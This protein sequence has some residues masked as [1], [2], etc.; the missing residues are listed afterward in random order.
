M[1]THAHTRARTHGRSSENLNDNP[2]RSGPHA[3]VLPDTPPNPPT[4]FTGKAASK[5]NAN[6][7]SWPAS[8]YDE[9]MWFKLPGQR[10]ELRKCHPPRKTPHT[11]LS[12]TCHFNKN[13]TWTEEEALRA[14]RKEQML[15]S[16]GFL[17]DGTHVLSFNSS[18][19]W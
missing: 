12:E 13:H 17:L 2:L 18:P 15:A 8:C 11:P 9:H 3:G 1:H 5:A 14:S 16:Y 6:A 19:K 4:L 10:L 7:T